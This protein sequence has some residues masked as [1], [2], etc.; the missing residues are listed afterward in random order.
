MI[1]VALNFN[2][3]GTEIPG[4]FSQWIYNFLNLGNEILVIADY[5]CVKFQVL[6]YYM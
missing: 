3:Q 6:L 5:E 4:L 1:K 2:S